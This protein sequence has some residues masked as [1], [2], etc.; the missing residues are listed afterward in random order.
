MV[1]TDF[2]AA[3]GGD[4]LG[5]VQVWLVDSNSTSS[6][7][8]PAQQALVHSLALLAHPLAHPLGHPLGPPLTTFP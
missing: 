1:D 7:L 2:T 4:Y 3:E 5:F 8:L 6:Q